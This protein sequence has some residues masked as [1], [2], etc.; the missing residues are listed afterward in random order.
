MERLESLNP[1]RIVWC[2]GDRGISIDELAA[3]TRIPYTSIERALNRDSSLTFGQIQK[4]ASYLGRGVL[5]FLEPGPVDEQAVHSTQF[6]TLANQKPAL[7]PKLKSIIERAEKQRAVYLTLLEELKLSDTQNYSPPDVRGKSPTEAA[8]LAREW[9]RVDEANSFEAYRS[10]IEGHGILVF[11]SNGYNGKWQIPKESLILGFSLYD[12]KC[13]LIV[14]RKQS[15]EVRQTFTLAH[16]LGHL[17]L[18]RSSSID[19]EQDLNANAGD[20]RDANVFAANFLVPD[21]YLERI[22]N[23]GIPGDPADI[24]SWLQDYRRAWGVSA[25]V[26]LLRLVSAGRIRQS[27]YP[28]YR[29]WKE[30]QPESTSVG[31]TRIYRHREPKHLFGDKFVHVVL[32]ALNSRKIT[33]T[34]ASRYLDSLKVKDLH[35]LESY[36]AGY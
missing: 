24:D 22:P 21:E 27:V 35:K 19:D 23:H 8:N 12:D 14:V 31:G 3:E 29:E 20:E 1:D 18:H 11:R 34:K 15:A 7:S 9:L 28:Q 2:C 30:Q 5:F 32:D 25:D 17:L 36:Y 4:I 16:E 13:P 33:I 10:A 6:R 26:I